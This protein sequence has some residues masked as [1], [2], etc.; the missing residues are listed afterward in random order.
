MS[1]SLTP[2]TVNGSHGEGGGALFRTILLLGALTERPVRVHNV[3]G[4]TRKP[5]L[6]SEDLTFVRLLEKICQAKVLGDEVKGTDLTFIP[7]RAPRPV[8]MSIDVQ[9]IEKGN[10]PGNALIILSSLLPVLARAGGFSRLIVGGETHNSN[11]LVYEVFER[12]SLEAHRR[13]GLYAFPALHRAGFGFAGHGEVG[14]EVEP[15]ALEGSDWARRGELIEAR[16]IVTYNEVQSSVAERGLHHAESLL[17]DAGLKAETELNAVQGNS[18][19]IFVTIYARYE[20]GMGCG[21]SIGSRGMRMELVVNN[22]F[23]QFM[24]WQRTDAAVDPFIADQLLIPAAIATGETMIT[25]S[26]ITKRLITIA[27]AIKQFFPIQV[28]VLGREGE[29]G[30]VKVVPQ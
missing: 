25:T 11:T 23:E 20:N 2:A 3:R 30:S 19:G 18:P 8:Q 27:W 4:G 5:G 13:Q 24:R 26:M 14:L 15:S 6:T 1:A 17:R 22:A 29:P 9:D 12:L 16:A 21:T 7:G 28:T 10:S